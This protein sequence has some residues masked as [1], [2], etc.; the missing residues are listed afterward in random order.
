MRHNRLGP[1]WLAARGTTTCWTSEP[2]RAFWVSPLPPTPGRDSAG[3]YYYRASPLKVA[4][5]DSRSMGHGAS[6]GRV[7]GIS[8]TL[9][10]C[11]T[12]L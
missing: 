3:Y 9:G 10:G 4:A 8:I 1:S 6:P 5:G 12:R 7:A 2:P 11:G